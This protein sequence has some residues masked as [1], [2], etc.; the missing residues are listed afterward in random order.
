MGRVRDRVGRAGIAAIG[1]AV[2]VF[3]GGSSA[4]AADVASFYKGRTVNLIIGYSVGG[5]YDLYARV[6][7]RHIGRHIPG[8]PTVVPQSMPGAGSIKA[9]NYLYAVAPKDGSVFGTFGRT[10]PVAPLLGNEVKIDA[11]K[12]S[13]IGSVTSDVSLCVVSSASPIKSWEDMLYKDYTF[14]GESAGSDPD[15][16]AL[17]IKNLFHTRLKLVTGYPGTADTMLGVQRGE[18]DGLCGLSYSTLKSRNGD[19]L[20]EGKINILVQASLTKEPALPDV[21]LLIDEV[22]TDE[23]RQILKLILSSQLMARPYAAPPGIPED[24]KAALRKAFDDT[25]QDPEF[26]AEMDKVKLD[27]NPIDGKA[28]EALL[29]DVYATPPDIAQKAA[30]AIAN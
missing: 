5:G 15:V 30:R 9:I 18:L 16:F 6:L 19:L 10:V 21:P 1:L 24:R 25:M 7:A 20:K 11:T 4:R 14:G 17:L 2:A 26:R 27:V 28:I 23:Q 13:W 22:K 8:N 12:L 29:A 3:L